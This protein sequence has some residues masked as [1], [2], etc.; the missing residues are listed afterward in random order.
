MRKLTSFIGILAIGSLCFSSNALALKPDDVLSEHIMEADGTSGQDTGTGS[1][2]KTGHIQD[3]AVTD[4][5]I[6]DVAMA[7][8]TGLAT[9][10]ADKADQTYVDTGLAVKAD[11]TS[12]DAALALKADQS[13]VDTALAAKADTAYVVTGLAAKAD[14]TSVDAALALKADLNHTHYYGNTTIVALSG[15]EYTSPLAAMNDIANWCGVPSDSNRCLIKIMGGVYDMT[16]STITMQDYVEIAG[17]GQT[18]TKLIVGFAAPAGNLDETAVRNMTIE[19]FSTKPF[20][21]YTGNPTTAN[22]R[23]SLSDLTINTN[24][25]AIDYG[26]AELIANDVTINI[27]GTSNVG[28]E[29]YG[30]RLS[31]GV[32]YLDNVGINI[33]SASFLRTGLWLGGHATYDAGLV[34]RNSSIHSSVPI[35]GINFYSAGSPLGAHRLSNV[36]IDIDNTA[37]YALNFTNTNGTNFKTIIDNANISAPVAVF[38]QA[39]GSTIELNHSYIDSPYNVVKI[40]P[41]ASAPFDVSI[42]ASRL[43][44]T[45]NNMDATSTVTCFNNYTENYTAYTCP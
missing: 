44:G 37:G 36:D 45:I 34:M 26:G 1:G 35:N 16:G 5:K 32:M 41:G 38:G 21:L 6:S 39:Y 15:G 8:V 2:I 31:Y 27:S 29:V 18:A 11:Q 4:A 43:K 20:S 22:G 3:G 12:V 9:A 33:S 10:L 25:P 17:S 14:Q 24:N 23:L 28:N 30:I 13:A 19:N 42:A 7:K 40:F